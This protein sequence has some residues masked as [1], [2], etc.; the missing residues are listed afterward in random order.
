MF[1]REAHTRM[2]IVGEAERERRRRLILQ[3]IDAGVRSM[4]S[5]L[6]PDIGGSAEDMQRLLECKKVLKAPYTKLPRLN[7]ELRAGVKRELKPLAR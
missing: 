5:K 2:L 4:A 1:D 3:I 7:R 6:H